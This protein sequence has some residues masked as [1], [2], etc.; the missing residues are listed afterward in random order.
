MGGGEGPPLSQTIHVL[1]GY[2]TVGREGVDLGDSKAR[3]GGHVRSGPAQ[4]PMTLSGPD[5]KHVKEYT[6]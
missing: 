5:K 1:I 4:Q 3:T 6:H 2:I